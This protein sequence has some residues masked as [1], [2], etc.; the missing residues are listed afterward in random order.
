MH[1]ELVAEGLAKITGQKGAEA[2]GQNGSAAERDVKG[3]F[4][5]RDA[6]GHRNKRRRSR[7]REA[8]DPRSSH[9]T[10]WGSRRLCWSC[11]LWSRVQC[12]S[13]R[14]RWGFRGCAGPVGFGVQGA[15]AQ[16]GGSVLYREPGSKPSSNKNAAW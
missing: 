9:R 14:T 7:S 8:R 10:R 1:E 6:D 5:G 2:P 16:T 4:S 11:R 13:H 12:S 15:G 3:E